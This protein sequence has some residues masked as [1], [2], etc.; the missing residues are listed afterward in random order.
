MILCVR[1]IYI[2]T[3][4]C[5]ADMLGLERTSYLSHISEGSKRT[6]VYIYVCVSFE[7]GQRKGERINVPKY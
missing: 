1:R 5:L 6:S 4:R 7:R 2:Y 3:E